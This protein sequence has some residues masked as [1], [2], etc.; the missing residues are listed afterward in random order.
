MFGPVMIHNSPM[1]SEEGLLFL[2]AIRPF[3]SIRHVF[4]ELL[5]AC[6]MFV[7]VNEFV[8]LPHSVMI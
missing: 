5:L 6:H 2:T 3:N 7:K 4:Y 8:R 1:G